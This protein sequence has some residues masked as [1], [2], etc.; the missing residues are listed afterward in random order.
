MLIQDPRKSRLALCQRFDM[1]A[2]TA[3]GPHHQLALAA[4]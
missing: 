1:I 3:R 2:D 4:A